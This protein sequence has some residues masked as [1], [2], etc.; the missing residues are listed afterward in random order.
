L[1]DRRI[2]EV[3]HESPLR[4]E[5]PK[6]SAQATELFVHD[7]KVLECPKRDGD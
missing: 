4:H 7:Q 6:D 3:E 5:M 2:E 1:W